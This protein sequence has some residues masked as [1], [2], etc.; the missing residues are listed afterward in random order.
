M[1]MRDTRTKIELLILAAGI[2]IA[3]ASPQPARGATPQAQVTPPLPQPLPPTGNCFADN[4]FYGAI[5]PGGENGRVL[6]FVHG[7]SGLA[8]DWWSEN[9]SAG[10][11]D[12]YF[13]AYGAGYR[14]AF[15]NDNVNLATPGNCTVVRRPASAVMGS[16]YVLSQQL[17]AITQHFGVEQVD[18][19]AHSKGGLDSQAAI[20]WWGGWPFVRKVFTLGT[21]HQGSLLADLLWSPEGFWVGVLLGQRDDATFSLQTGPMQL[22]RLATDPNLADDAIRYYTGVGN[23]WQTPGTLFLLTGEWLQN[24]PEGGDNDGVVDVAHTHLPGATP[25]FLQ[26]WNH[27]ELYQGRNAFP[28]IHQILEANHFIYLPLATR[29]S[30]TATGQTPTR[31]LTALESNFILRG[32]RLM[33]TTSEQFPIEPGVRAANFIVLTTDER[34]TVTLLGPDGSISPLQALADDAGAQGIFASAFKWGGAVT[35]PKPGQWAIQLDGP[36]GTGYL[37][38]TTLDSPLHVSLKGLPDHFIAPGMP[39]QLGALSQMPNS[40]TQVSQLRLM[41]GQ[42]ASAALSNE[43]AALGDV[44]NVIVSPGASLNYSFPAEGFYN[45]SLSVSGAT[46]EGWPFERSFIRSVV[47]ASPETFTDASAALALLVRK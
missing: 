26:P 31:A 35:Q 22:F 45:L 33:G 30:Q 17:V 37:L 24:N 44:G 42:S 19:V 36:P 18:I 10:P 8:E 16:G 29:G 12:M 46:A 15:V 41:V 43:V 20:V 9:S 3:A 34:A 38:L 32:G 14:T 11:N 5:P 7:L 39:I 1:V 23:F 2:L 28:Y 27:T 13:Q 6:V 21:P 40:S 4:V 25:L 47:V